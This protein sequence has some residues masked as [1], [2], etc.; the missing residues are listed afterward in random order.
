MNKRELV[1]VISQE[2]HSSVSQERI[3]VILGTGI[4]VIKRALDGGKAVNGNG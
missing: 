4:E 3:A 2:L 1:C